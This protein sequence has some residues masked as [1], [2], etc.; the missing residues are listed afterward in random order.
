M[1]PLTEFI[2]L[3]FPPMVAILGLSGNLMGFL[4]LSR[5]NMSKLPI[6]NTYRF[7]FT[8][9]SIFISQSIISYM[10]YGL[11][12]DP[13]MSSIYFCK[14]FNYFNYS[15][16][17]TSPLLLV[18]ISSER[19]I[20]IKFPTKSSFYK[21][22]KFQVIYLVS[23]TLYGL[24]FYLGIAFSFDIIDINGTF[25]NETEN[26]TIQQCTF[27]DPILLSVFSW[28]DLMNRAIVPSIV[29]VTISCLLSYSIF[30]SRKR[31]AGT[32]SVLENKNFKKDL[33]YT[34]TSIF[35]NLVYVLLNLPISITIFFP[36]YQSSSIYVLSFFLFYFSYGNNFY[37]I[38]T[39]NSLIRN[40]FLLFLGL[41]S[42]VRKEP[43]MTRT[44]LANSFKRANKVI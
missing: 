29:M 3:I 34:I 2:Y 6:K 41:R 42:L 22:Q 16:S 33:K 7:L 20:S 44:T 31:V 35:L 15:L 1:N 4:V 13:T 28:L 12:F 17:I 39:F 32:Q 9:D 18:Y 21:T 37:I 8:S 25:I 11:N 23:A 30:Q 24:L 5:K 10:Q 27:K 26:E 36:N 43:S 14:A 38:I 40:E 19:L